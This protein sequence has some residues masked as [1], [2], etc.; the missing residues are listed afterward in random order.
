PDYRRVDIGF[1]AVIKKEDKKSKV[2]LLNK[3]NSIWISVEVFNLLDID[4]TVSYLWVADVS[5]RQYAVPNYLTPRQL[6]F[7]LIVSL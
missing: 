6:N 1:S 2:N 5:G 7:K 3:L 4:N